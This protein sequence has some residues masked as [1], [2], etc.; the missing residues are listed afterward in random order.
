M[1]TLTDLASGQ[2]QSLLQQKETP[3]HGLRI[4]VQG[5][6]CAGWQYGMRYEDREREGDTIVEIQGVR[7]FVDSFSAGFLEGAT[8]DYQ[9]TPRGSGF[10]VNNPNAVAYCACGQSFRTEGE[11]GPDAEGICDL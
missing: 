5:G 2:L 10:R 1:I 11:G 7:L 4:F 3:D 8:I 9:D 6:G